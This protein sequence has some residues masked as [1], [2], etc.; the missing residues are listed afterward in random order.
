[1]QTPKGCTLRT[2]EVLRCVLFVACCVCNCEPVVACHMLAREVG[3]PT[4]Q[5]DF[6][7]PTQSNGRKNAKKSFFG[8]KR[9]V[10]K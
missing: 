10:P 9:E 1:M 5:R 6:F 7:S 8:S 4:V 2:D 3:F